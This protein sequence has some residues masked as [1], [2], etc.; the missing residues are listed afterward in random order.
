MGKVACRYNY[1]GTGRQVFYDASTYEILNAQYPVWYKND[2]LGIAL[3]TTNDVAVSATGTSAAA[4]ISAGVNGYVLL[5]TGTD[6]DLVSQITGELNYQAGHNLIFQC[7]F[8]TTTSDAD[9]LIYAGLAD[10]KL[11]STA[12]LPITDGSLAAASI[13]SNT[14]DLVGFAVRT[15]TSDNIYA[16]SCKNNATP[17]STDTGLDLTIDT[18]YILEIVCD[19][20]G[21]AVFYVDGVQVASHTAAITGTDNLCWYVGALLTDGSTAAFVKLDY[22]LVAQERA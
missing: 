18:E 8:S 6:V 21:N 1:K 15:E 22:V 13:D 2:F 17:Q 11:V 5:D 12:A 16:V 10:T 3:D 9:V 19:T 14:P 7:K 20:S 4:E